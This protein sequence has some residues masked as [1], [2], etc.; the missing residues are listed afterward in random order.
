MRL[1][2]YISHNSNYSRREA[3]RLIAEEK[4]KVNK[5]TITEGFADVSD[6][7][8][9]EISSRPLKPK[10]DNFYTVIV[11]NKQ[12]G[13]LVTKKDDRG[14]KTIYDSLPH[15][16]KHFLPVGRLDFMSEGLLILSDS[17][18]VV[19]ALMHSDFERMYKLKIE[20][21]I[22][23]QMMENM[24]DGLE[25]QDSLAGAHHLSQIDNM[26]IS[27]FIAY[28]ILKNDTKY[29]KLKVVIG[30]GQNRELRRFFGHFNKNVVD[31]KRIA[32]G[33]FTL[34][35]LPSGKFRYF[36]KKEYKEL[37]S[38]LKRIDKDDARE[39]EQNEEDNI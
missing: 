29:S 6:E 8:D 23:K 32:F 9:I 28:N 2:K 24:E 3:D 21:D 34:D 25:I 27:P 12:K 20:G 26:L 1:N 37:R 19:D 18:K 22:T 31:L 13:E 14:R 17:P 38:Y 33:S 16:F 36:D 15:K 5:K 35:S 11:Y 4:V 10:D 39:A 7:D 30:E